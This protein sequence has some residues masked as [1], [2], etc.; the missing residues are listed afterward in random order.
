MKI[1]HIALLLAILLSAG[2]IGFQGHQLKE[3]IIEPLGLEAYMEKS[4]FELP[5][6][7][8]TDEELLFYIEFADELLAEMTEPSEP[9]QPDIPTVET[10]PATEP[11]TAPST[12]PTQTQPTETQPSTDSTDPTTVPTEPT[13]T[14][15]TEPPTSETTK[16]TEP[17]PTNPP[18]QKEEPTFDFPAERVDDSWFDNTLFIGDSRMTGLKI[19]AR[20][21]KADYFCEPS[22]TFYKVFD[23][24]LDDKNFEK[25]YLEELLTSRTYDKIIVN[26]GLNEASWSN[27]MFEK[28]FEQFL[29]KLRGLQPNAKIIINGIMPVTKKYIDTAKY[30]GPYWEPESLKKK[31]DIL[32]SFA[33]GV[34]VFYIDCNEY[35]ADSKGYLFQSVTGDGCHPTATHYKTWR[36]WMSWALSTLGI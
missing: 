2:Y 11:S 25:Q 14:Q 13:Q 16:P 6:L 27:T 21:G 29:E 10:P 7:A 35:F 36:E 31:S 1:K 9:Q 28:R 23:K 5:F 20:A 17:K 8:K 18:A 32:A 26:F 12:Q 19:Y 4:I 34:N 3:Q 22:L 24:K 33:D 15:P 30:G